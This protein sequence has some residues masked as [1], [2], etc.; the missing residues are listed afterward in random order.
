MISKAEIQENANFIK[1]LK[2][3]NAKNNSLKKHHVEKNYDKEIYNRFAEIRKYIDLIKL[4][5]IN[6][7]NLLNTLHV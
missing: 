2:F 5:Q 4:E 7:K 1:N 3:Y 6:I